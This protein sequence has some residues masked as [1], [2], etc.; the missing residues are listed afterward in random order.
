MKNSSKSSANAANPY[1]VL[2]VERKAGLGEIK[3]AYFTLVREF[4]PEEQPEKFKEIR[5][6]YEQLKSPTKRAEIDFFLLQPAPELTISKSGRYDLTVHPEDT[7]R[8]ALELRLAEL[9]FEKDFRELDI[10]G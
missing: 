4:P 10:S 9:S 3:K 1:N 5:T 8:L 6:A 2:G 7:I